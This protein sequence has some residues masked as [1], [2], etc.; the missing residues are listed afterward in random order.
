MNTQTKK[1]LTITAVVV[2]HLGVITVMVA[3]PGCKSDSQKSGPAEP[4]ASANITPPADVVATTPPP[5]L[6]EPTR[7]A[8]EPVYT[9]PPTIPTTPVVVTHMESPTEPIST[10]SI[11]V[12][13]P[14]PT[15][16]PTI[17]YE[18]KSTDRGLIP[19]ARANGVTLK[20]LLAANPKLTETSVIHVGDKINI[21]HSAATGTAATAPATTPDASSLYTVVSGD[22]LTVIARKL[23]TTIAALKSTN[24]LKTDTVVA[25]QKLTIPAAGSAP[26]TTST[27]SSTT[28]ATAAASASGTYTVVAGDNP[29]VIARKLGVSQGD[30][31]NANPD[32]KDPAKARALRPGSTVNV[33]ANSKPGTETSTPSSSTPGP[34]PMSS[35]PIMIS[36]P[37]P[38]STNTT[39]TPATVDM[40]PVA[41]VH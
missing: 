16:P 21:V 32:L 12:T 2:F 34:T 18:V 24:N 30:F 19:I 9:P 20:E 41:P 40:V 29:T 28:T 25:G 15:P 36:P 1:I 14:A 17:I 4:A 35:Q 39:V 7:P 23:H 13:P 8:P 31:L 11:P 37:T 10:P 38:A 3:Q 6:S 27:S 26:A 5:V 33:P 22:N